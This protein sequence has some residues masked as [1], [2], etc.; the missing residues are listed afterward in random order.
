[1]K[2][3]F[4]RSFHR[5]VENKMQVFQTFWIRRIYEGR[6]FQLLY[7][8]SGF[9]HTLVVCRK[10]RYLYALYFSLS[11]SFSHCSRIRDGADY[12]IRTLTWRREIILLLR[13]SRVKNMHA[14]YDTEKRISLRHTRGTLSSSCKS[15]HI[16]RNIRFSPFIFLLHF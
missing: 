9:S 2:K 14:C 12:C 4:I 15:A 16:H 5:T 3:A 7:F 11:L 8:C 6:C 1:M 10:Q 13:V